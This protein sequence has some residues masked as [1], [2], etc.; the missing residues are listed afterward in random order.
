M[1]KEVVTDAL[2]IV[3]FEVIDGVP[4]G[5][6][7]LR[8]TGRVPKERMP[9]WRTAM[10]RLNLLAGNGWTI[11]ISQQYFIPAPVAEMVK[12]GGEPA[13]GSHL[14]SIWRIIIQAKEK[15]DEQLATI[16]EHINKIQPPRV[17]LM[18]VTLNAPENRNEL[19]RGKGAQP[20]GQAVVGPMI[21]QQPRK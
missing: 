5:E 17:E 9:T 6:L 4:V 2:P 16:A 15:V 7:Q 19:R 3:G 21:F 13:D 20:M 14:R 12:A 18:E 1:N 8:I 11:D 10:E